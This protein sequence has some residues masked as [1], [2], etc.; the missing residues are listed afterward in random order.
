MSAWCKNIISDCLQNG[1]CDLLICDKILTY[2]YRLDRS[3][4]SSFHTDHKRHYSNRAD[5]GSKPLHNGQHK[6]L[7]AAGRRHLDYKIKQM[8]Y[9]NKHTLQSV[10]WGFSTAVHT[11]G[12]QRLTGIICIIKKN[13]INCVIKHTLQRP[14]RMGLLRSGPRRRL[15]TAN[16]HHLDYKIKQN[17]LCD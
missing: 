6:R 15:S 5:L 11:G 9:V 2:V 12:C 3:H 7:S 14:S 8:N 1:R 13:K 4:S 16:R 17:N 10:H